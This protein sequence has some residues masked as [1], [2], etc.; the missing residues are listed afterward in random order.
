MET[1]YADDFL[2][3]ALNSFETMFFNEFFSDKFT[4]LTIGKTLFKSPSMFLND[5]NRKWF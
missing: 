5:L 1:I 2:L 3:L 4:T